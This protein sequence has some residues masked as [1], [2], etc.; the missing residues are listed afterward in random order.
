MQG[1]WSSAW[2]EALDE[3]VALAPDVVVPGHGPPCGIEGPKEMKAYLEYVRSEAKRFFDR[4]LT[5][6]EAARRIDLGPY[7][8]WTEPERL[9][10]NVDR[11][12]REML[13]VPHDAPIDAA[14][15]FRDM[16]ALGAE[17]GFAGRS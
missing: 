10:F 8:G 1:G 9:V 17:P 11:A 3:I 7:A 6:F 14:G 2:I 15:L 13:G 12:Y 16:F 4:G 5:P